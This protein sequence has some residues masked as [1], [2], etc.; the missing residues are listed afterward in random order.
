[1]KLQ[2]IVLSI[3]FFSLCSIF[4]SAA[5][6]EELSITN[7]ALGAST[8]SCS[9]SITASCNVVNTISSIPVNAVTFTISGRSVSGSLF[10]GNSTNG[11]WQ[12]TI[13]NDVLLAD[14]TIS[15]QYVSASTTSGKT[16][17][18]AGA[19]D[20]PAGCHVTFGAQISASNTCSCTYSASIGP[21]TIYNTQVTTYT[22]NSACTTGASENTAFVDYCDPLWQASYGACTGTFTDPANP[23]L[24]KMLKTYTKGDPSCCVKT[25]AGAGYVW[26]NHNTGSDCKEPIDQGTYISCNMDP[27]TQ[28]GLDS[29]HSF[30]DSS[31]NFN[32][33][34]NTNTVV[35][36]DV[37][38]QPL[39]YDFNNDGRDE[40]VVFSDLSGV[41]VKLY[42]NSLTL[43]D[44]DS[45][46]F[47]A[48]T[49][50]PVLAGIV[51]NEDGTYHIPL[52]TNATSDPYILVPVIQ[53]GVGKVAKYKVAGTSLNFIEYIVT[54]SS[55]AGFTGIMCHGDAC[56]FADM[57]PAHSYM[58]SYDVKLGLANNVGL[59]NGALFSFG[60]VNQYNH[61]SGWSIHS[62]YSVHNLPPVYLDSGPY[63]GFLVGN[64]SVHYVMLM[65]GAGTPEN[66]L[67]VSMIMLYPESLVGS[68]LTAWSFPG[69]SVVSNN[70]VLSFSESYVGVTNKTVLGVTGVNVHPDMFVGGGTYATYPL[71]T[72]ILWQGSVTDSTEGISNIATD[73]S[74]HNN[75]RAYVKV[76]T[77]T[78]S[79][80]SS[81]GF[82]LPFLNK[83]TSN[84]VFDNLKSGMVVSS[85]K[86]Y[87][88]GVGY[89]SVTTYYAMKGFRIS[90]GFNMLNQQF[91][92]FSYAGYNYIYDQSLKNTYYYELNNKNIIITRSLARS[93]SGYYRGA[94][95]KYD[96]S[97]PLSPNNVGPI[98]YSMGQ[99]TSNELYTIKGIF[100]PTSSNNPY[101][102]YVDQYPQFH[103]GSPTPILGF[104]SSL[105][106]PLS[107]VIKSE[108]VGAGLSY[109]NSYI[110]AYDS[111][112][113]LLYTQSEIIHNIRSVTN[114]THTL[115][116]PIGV[117][118]QFG[119]RSAGEA[120][121]G[122]KGGL[123]NY[124]FERPR[125]IDSE[126]H[127]VK[128][129]IDDPNNPTFT[130]TTATCMFNS[131]YGL[132]FLPLLYSSDSYILGIN[133]RTVIGA[134]PQFAYCDFTD[135]GAPVIVN[136]GVVAPHGN[137]WVAVGT[138]PNGY[139]IWERPDYY[140]VASYAANNMVYDGSGGWYLIA[141]NRDVG[142]WT[143]QDL[144]TGLALYD[145]D[146]THVPVIQSSAS[147]AL[148][149][150][151]Y[152]LNTDGATDG[153][154]VSSYTSSSKI[155]LMDYAGEGVLDVVTPDGFY[156]FNTGQFIAFKTGNDY[157]GESVLPI[158]I[159]SDG[160]TDLLTYG[161]YS[162]LRLV[163]TT[164]S[165]DAIQAGNLSI[166]KF[167]CSQIP[168]TGN[169]Q[170]RLA[171]T[172]PAPD[173]MVVSIDPG[174][175][176]GYITQ[177][178]T[179]YTG[180]YTV[181]YSSSGTY[182]STAKVYDSS[183]PFNIATASC[184]IPVTVVGVT[185]TKTDCSLGADG[186]FE[187]SDALIKHNWVGS[188]STL[189]PSSG[190]VLLTSSSS[191][192]YGLS[193]CS[194]ATISAEMKVISGTGGV[195]F[196]LVGSD[197]ANVVGIN[198]LKAT[199]GKSAI[200]D[201][202][203]NVIGQYDW[204]GN[205]YLTLGLAVDR[206]N[207][208]A[209]YTLN[210]ASLTSKSGK[211]MDI[212]SVQMSGAGLVDY[213][214]SSFA[215]G[216]LQQAEDTVNPNVGDLDG[217]VAALQKC[218]A[219]K[220]ADSSSLEVR[221]SYPNVDVYC[222]GRSN[223]PIGVCNFAAL[224]AM[225]SRYP[226]CTKEAY[227][228][229]V[230]KAFKY[231]TQNAE[232]GIAGGTACTALI[233]GSAV[234]SQTVAPVMSGLWHVV[235]S[236][237]LYVVIFVVI[238]VIIGLATSMGKRS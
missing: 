11:V 2:G 154:V 129:N 131:G 142:E 168:N 222:Q 212:A 183:N 216:V 167:E 208:Q 101:V 217:N 231:E 152:K 218:D 30:K 12:G 97:D 24:G 65:G 145:L 213:V 161:G 58:Y 175:G 232:G 90:D 92:G 215:G 19:T 29:V 181:P 45:Q 144:S 40:I 139:Y 54:S 230:Y 68:T 103:L 234:I 126:G 93:G 20:V 66:G 107:S 137:R 8:Y 209:H 150:T 17:S 237:L 189:S 108:M 172:S 109:P 165:A 69:M 177:A 123:F 124:D 47:T 76:S 72:N 77:K 220:M 46:S 233:A 21:K 79:G 194:Y 120:N 146:G 71:Y 98:Y 207:G 205:T 179:S 191:F 141:T 128:I 53:G 169:V 219:S 16:C 136:L 86:Q 199:S 155:G 149:T 10:S 75:P 73:S 80:G 60:E 4:A 57:N 14:Q 166:V 42:S 197:S 188:P 9:D 1:M 70:I 114:V 225:S 39:M 74:D 196:K 3:V 26:F 37:V 28:S 135:E 228:Y 102:V 184:S 160:F 32:I 81:T 105:S 203:G 164:P 170:F 122:N 113:D 110:I 176:R 236:N 200:L 55:S 130:T 44:S 63:I 5:T 163:T 158:D 18:G 138:Q 227:N 27:V 85:D 187:Y 185:S 84:F 115:L 224:S 156:D 198:I 147:S 238:L 36:D 33:N 221:R 99:S 133:L 78:Y 226:E 100:S 210:G 195:V 201:E 192:N 83:F 34:Q 50:Q 223:A 182:T 190:K 132:E 15:L 87:V 96:V 56:Y 91:T 173:D 62:G 121:I 180:T 112:N 25:S 178:V 67:P 31:T 41:E 48:I 22:P 127:K 174:D 95:M 6:V 23:L 119:M 52:T 153:S 104:V 7:C 49:G 59:G 64:I 38:Y 51:K 117:A 143:Q 157:P 82:L 148:S 134:S 89:N 140:S 61:G 125:Y 159:N 151:V 206:L 106:P 186:E 214:R 88:Y 13:A 193:K 204:N 171:A 43:L 35:S 94:I 116:P 118:L 111:A 202:A 235:L 211:S 229:C 162:R